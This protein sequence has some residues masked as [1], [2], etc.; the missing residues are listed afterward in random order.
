[1]GALGAADR[2][3]IRVRGPLGDFHPRP[4]LY[5]RRSVIAGSRSRPR[6]VLKV[7]SDSDRTCAR[8]FRAFGGG[9]T[10]GPCSDIDHGIDGKIA[11]SAPAWTCDAT[12]LKARRSSDAEGA[13]RAAD[14]AVVDDLRGAGPGQRTARRHDRSC[15]VDP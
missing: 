12:W 14:L 10:R 2:G 15:A 8:G 11:P 1:M 6:R 4:A 3:F 13:P 9:G 5:L 7:I